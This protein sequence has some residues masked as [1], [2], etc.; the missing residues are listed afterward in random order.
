M[1]MVQILQGLSYKVCSTTSPNSNAFELLILV[2]G[3]STIIHPQLT[4]TRTY[5]ICLYNKIANYWLYE[6]ETV[7]KQ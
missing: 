4:L 5:E 6:E 2:F 7:N 1:N 3:I